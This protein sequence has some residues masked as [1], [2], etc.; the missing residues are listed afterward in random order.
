MSPWKCAGC[1]CEYQFTEATRKY[2]LPFCAACADDP[3]KIK[4]ATA[5]GR[6]S[7]GWWFALGILVGMM[8][9]KILFCNHP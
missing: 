1:H 4:L 9:T 5:M 6:M 3:D 7:G 8:A 2:G